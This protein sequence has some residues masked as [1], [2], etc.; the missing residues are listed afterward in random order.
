MAEKVL[1]KYSFPSGHTLSAA[2]V[3]T[4][5]ALSLPPVL[6]LVVIGWLLIA[7]SRI[8]LAHHYPSDVVAGGVAGTLIGL[9]VN[10]LIT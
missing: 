1:D 5:F 9:A 8:A 7:W 6:P 3:G 2:A 4:S 10:G